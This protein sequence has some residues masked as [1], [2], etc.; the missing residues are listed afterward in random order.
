MS[1]SA[2]ETLRVLIVEDNQHMRALLRMLLNSI[3]IRE[4][5]EAGNGTAALAVLRDKRCDLVL[6]DLAMKPMDGIDFT[7]EIRQS[8]RSANPFMPIIMITGHTEKQRVEAARDAGVT[9]FLA[10]PITAQSLFS[11]IAQIVEYP[12]PFVRCGAYFGPDRR[13]KALDDYAGPWRRHDDF[14]DLHVQ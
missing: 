5:H 11:R 8:A 12:R 4:I 13:R 10:K 3:G 6:S 2:F 7:R 9:E 14:R 1:E